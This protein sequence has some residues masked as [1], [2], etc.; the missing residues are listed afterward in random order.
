MM[1]KIC[2]NYMII[3]FDLIVK[4]LRVVEIQNNLKNLRPRC[5]F[6]SKLKESLVLLVPNNE[7]CGMKD[8]A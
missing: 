2:N 1:D 8:G 3:S 5:V 6:I 4:E 7:L